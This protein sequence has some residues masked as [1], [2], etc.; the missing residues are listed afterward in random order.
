MW[1]W[2]KRWADWLRNDRLPLSRVRRGGSSIHIR[3]DADGESHHEL[4]VPWS[5]DVVTVEALLRLPPPARRKLDFALRFPGS[6]AIVADGVRPEHGNR[7]RVIFRFAPPLTSVSGEILWKS[8]PIARVAIPVLTASEFLNTLTLTSPLL[9]VRHGGVVIPARFF[10]PDGVHSLLASVTLS[11]PYSLAPLAEL[12]LQAVFRCERTGQT[13]EIPMALTADQRSATEAVVTVVCPRRPRRM[14]GWSIVWRAGGR[15]LA[16]RRAEAISARRFDDSVRVIDARFVVA[17]KSGAVSVL[18][19]IPGTTTVDRL[20]PSFLLASNERGAVGLCRLSVFAT[21]PGEGNPIE[22]ASREVLVTDAPTGFA[23]GLFASADLV[24]VG[25]FELRLNDRLLGT[26]SL[27]PVPPAALTSEGGF[28]PPP[29]FT[30]TT[31]AEEELLDRLG[32]LGGDGGR[33]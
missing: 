32:R 4:P 1:R 16:L 26:A 22:L 5:A 33:G 18:R 20:G 8:Q 24:R 14:G 25:G 12:N 13:H 23:P 10:V 19:Q 27:S 7:H 11:S 29:N 2:I 3:Y 15:D 28:K 9:A 17:E 6:N 30:W 31:A 21:A